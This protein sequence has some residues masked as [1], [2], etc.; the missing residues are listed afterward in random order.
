MAKAKPSKKSSAKDV[1][2]RMADFIEK[3]RKTPPFRAV[4]TRHHILDFKPAL[5]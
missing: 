4:D 1:Y 5:L 2:A 3:H